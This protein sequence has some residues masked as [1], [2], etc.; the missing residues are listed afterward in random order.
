VFRAR[1][2]YTS[3]LV[4]SILLGT[5]TELGIQE[6]VNNFHASTS[7]GARNGFGKRFK[8]KI[9]LATKMLYSFETRTFKSCCLALAPIIFLV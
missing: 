1:K 3:V 9:N 7:E 8:I 6:T 4:W 5:L 2:I